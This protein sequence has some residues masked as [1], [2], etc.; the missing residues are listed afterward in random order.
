MCG[1]CEVVC[2]RA[3]VDGRRLSITAAKVTWRMTQPFKLVIHTV[4]LHTK[5]NL[6]S[7]RGSCNATQLLMHIHIHIHRVKFKQYQHH[8]INPS[9]KY[10]QINSMMHEM[11]EK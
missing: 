7:T 4:R 1:A 11:A 8:V 2:T 6:I 9:I 3:F 5:K 10:T